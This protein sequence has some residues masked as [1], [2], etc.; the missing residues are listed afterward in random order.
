M[1]KSLL[2][3]V[4]LLCLL[5]AAAS[6]QVSSLQGLYDALSGTGTTIELGTSITGTLEDEDGAPAGFELENFIDRNVTFTGGKTISYTQAGAADEDFL[7]FCIDVAGGSLTFG[8]AITV[9]GGYSDSYGTLYLEDGELSTKDITFSKNYA[10]GVFLLGNS[11]KSKWTATGKVSFLDNKTYGGGAG[12]YSEGGSI[13]LTEIDAQ[14]NSASDYGGV[15]YLTDSDLTVNGTAVFGGTAATSGNRSETGG[16]AIFVGYDSTAVFNGAATFQNNSA[17]EGS[18]GGAI[19][20]DSAT[21]TFKDTATFIS[22][23]ATSDGGAVAAVSGT[24]TF[25]KAVSVSGNTTL[26][27]YGGAFNFY[28]STV[29]FKDTATF[30]DNLVTNGSGGA[31]YVTGD[32]E[33]VRITGNS[34]FSGNSAVYSAEDD[35]G[36]DG[37]AVYADMLGTVG[38]GGQ[39]GWNAT[40][41]TRFSQNRARRGAALFATGSSLKFGETVISENT[42]SFTDT[43]GYSGGGVVFL[44]DSEIT[45]TGNLLAEKNTAAA[46]SG[47]AVYSA[48]ISLLTFASNT[49]ATFSDN[50][51]VRGGAV[52][53]EE[54]S[55]LTLKLDS[56]AKVNIDKGATDAAGQNDVFLDTGSQLVINTDAGAVFALNST[57]RSNETDSTDTAVVKQGTGTVRIFGD[58]SHYTGGLTIEQGDLKLDTNGTLGSTDSSVLSITNGGRLIITLQDDTSGE[59]AAARLNLNDLVLDTTADGALVV[60]KTLTEGTDYALFAMDDSDGDKDLD[61]WKTA[62]QLD[63]SAPALVGVDGDY[64]LAYKQIT[65]DGKSVFSIEAQYDINNP[66]NTWTFSPDKGDTQT[67]TSVFDNSL[68]NNLNKVLTVNGEGTTALKPAASDNNKVGALIGNGNLNI[69][70][71]LTTTA[72]SANP[73]L[74]NGT[75]EFTGN[76]SGT[77]TFVKDGDY[78]Q[79]LT[80]T[81]DGF[82]GSTEVKNGTLIGNTDS[83]KNEVKTEQAGTLTFDQTTLADFESNPNR[84]FDGTLTG[85]GTVHI[86]GSND[87][88]GPLSG[89]GQSSTLTFNRSSN[90][91]T[92]TVNIDTG[93]LTLSESAEIKQASF[94]VGA[95]GGLGGNGTAG[96]V[97]VAPGGAVQAYQG[98]LTINGDL[99][100]QSGAQTG[101]M[102]VSIGGTGEPTNVLSVLGTAFVSGA[103]VQIIGVADDYV[104]NTEVK[105]ITGE[106]DGI[107]INDLSNQGE[108]VFVDEDSEKTW[109]FTIWKNTDGDYIAKGISGSQPP[110]PPEPPKPV[111]IGINR[112]QVVNA[113][114]GA[115]DDPDASE[116]FKS[117]ITAVNGQK[118]LDGDGNIIGNESFLNATK[119]LAG[120]V[121]VNGLQLGLYSPYRTVFNRLSLGSELYGGQVI[122]NDG[123]GPVS[124]IQ[125]KGAGTGEVFRGQ[126]DALNAHSGCDV[127]ACGN[128]YYFGE[129][130]FWAD[131][132]HVQTKVSGD[133]NS[134]GFGISRTGLL[135]GMD[136]QKSPAFRIGG[137]FGYY[138]PYL[139]QNSDRIEADDYHGGL[140]FQKNHFGTDVLGYIGYAHQSYDTRRITELML[141]DQ[142]YYGL[143]KGKT[144]GDSMSLSL[145]LSRPRYYGNS[146]IVRPLLGLDYYYTQQDGFTEQSVDNPLFALQYSKADYDQLFVR[147]GMNIKKESYRSAMNFRIQYINQFGTDPYASGRARFLSGGDVQM[148]IRGVNLGRDYLNLGSGIN[149]FMNQARSRFVS[150]DYDLNMSKKTTAHALSLILVERF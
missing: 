36:G 62:L 104:E 140:Y 108:L 137:V 135:L 103:E 75:T 19:Y 122:Y 30:T 112:S 21:L 22:N 20:L 116:E 12:L 73:N 111:F 66:N 78:T 92:G 143:Y 147:A 33:A 84:T 57:L 5:S 39:F 124:G 127:P 63:G 149:V 7:T 41:H 1:K 123:Y 83:L 4:C 132:T 70:K 38:S 8:S 26:N 129:N 96:N 100:F 139:W 10:P 44:E 47:G 3:A 76:L 31:V 49:Q 82:T 32:E 34:T 117:F 106:I 145:E 134:D 2:P 54:N 29:V 9:S 118:V 17:A 37:G 6:A 35:F 130:N 131:V 144:S 93:W 107:F 98:N 133:D 138:A 101:K 141:S 61:W 99:N 150:F 59:S 50:T 52:F 113:L 71:N 120:S 128:P 90:D 114:N 48:G 119:Q 105:F 91:F 142:G 23:K 51:A 56:G 14:R 77:G 89:K 16:G 28:D 46:G 67:I 146:I 81:A 45:F 42:A 110:P 80:G 43:D 109:T 86:K 115:E 60:I 18:G 24:L 148:T 85:S 97:T 53:V 11:G 55:V 102:Y 95:D 68:A 94:V 65:V 13:T 125:Y 15:I 121:R 79:K 87:I 74:T 88:P 27:A 58:T 69:E 64:L 126:Q 72:A 40:G 136:F 25:E